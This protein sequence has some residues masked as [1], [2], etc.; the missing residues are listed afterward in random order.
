MFLDSD[1]LDTWLFLGPQLESSDR[2]AQ[3]IAEVRETLDD[4]ARA[5]EH[6]SGSKPDL[7]GVLPLLPGAHL[8]TLSPPE[9]ERAQE[10]A[11]RLAKYGTKAAARAE[12]FLLDVIGYSRAPEAV[13]FWQG[14]LALK[15]G[16]GKFAERRRRFALAA[17]AFL[18][19]R[20]DHPAAY[21]ALDAALRHPDA[22]ARAYAA[23]YLGSAYGTAERPLPEATLAALHAVATADAAFE[24]RYEARAT[25]RYLGYPVP[26]DN[27]GGVYVFKV[28][29]RGDRSGATRTLAL[30]SEQTL[31]LIHI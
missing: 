31:S 5:L 12:E 9:R 11:A 30:R 23:Y 13:P 15:R 28:K 17:L 3:M 4:L 25:L 21:A 14:L 24:P 10:L 7:A 27:P 2:G 29:L 16:Q 26:L 22:Q 18:A 20:D 19:I 1:P 8:V 6:P